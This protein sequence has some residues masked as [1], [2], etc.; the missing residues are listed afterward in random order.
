MRL[1]TDCSFQDLGRGRAMD[2]LGD[3]LSE[4]EAESAR[5]GQ[6]HAQGENRWA[7]TNYSTVLSLP[8]LLS[9]IR[10]VNS[11]S[12][13]RHCATAHMGARMGSFCATPVPFPTR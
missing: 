5:S 11:S 4:S 10:S 6:P 2:D 8:R 3:Q 9:S 13:R 7:S 1:L 12:V